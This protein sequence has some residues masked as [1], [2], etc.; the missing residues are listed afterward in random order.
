RD[1]CTNFAFMTSHS[2]NRIKHVD[3]KYG[4]AFYAV[5]VTGKEAYG[6]IE[7]YAKIF[8]G[9]RDSNYYHDCG[10]I[11]IGENW[12]VARKLFGDVQYDGN[13]ITIGAYKIERNR[14]ENH[15]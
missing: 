6:N 4:E 11:G 8:V 1:F 3:G 9:S 13:V 7:V 14:Y 10:K 2:G 5:E 12:Q 15:R